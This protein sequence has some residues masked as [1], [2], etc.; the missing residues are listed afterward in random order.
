[1]FYTMK[2]Y[3]I[4]AFAVLG[5][6]ACTEPNVP[7]PAVSVEAVS[8]D[9]E[10]LQLAVGASVT[11]VATVEPKNAAT[12]EWSSSNPAV[13]VVVNGQVTG[14]AD[15]VAVVAA[16]AG[17]KVATCVVTVGNAGGQSGQGG[18]TTSFEQ[19]LEGSD[20]YIFLMDDKAL[21][22]IKGT[23]HDYRINGDYASPGNPGEGVTCTMDI[24]NGDVTDANFGT[25]K[26][27]SAFGDTDVEWMYWKSG[28]LA[29]GNI[30]GGIRQW[31]ECD[32]TEVTE[33]YDF[34][35]IYR[36]PRRLAG[37][38]V[39]VRLFSTTGGEHAVNSGMI[40]QSHG[41]WDVAEWSMAEWF[42]DGLDWSQTIVGSQSNVVYT[43]AL[44][45]E[46]GGRELEI[47]A[48]FCY[49]K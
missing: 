28:S 36:T 30:C 11:L 43:P 25:C 3:I 12:V 47:C 46:G 16:A 32:F 48:I 49:K 1:M 34:I 45:V 42:A 2:K 4:I 33:D 26:G 14:I 17:S 6:F 18:T 37:T 21:S 39:S 5:L 27:A 13:A 29:W 22:R 15:G 44:V 38:S 7:T 19:Y 35:I 23:V 31:G 24:W 20:Y 8:L 9:R 40:S 41:E 10:T